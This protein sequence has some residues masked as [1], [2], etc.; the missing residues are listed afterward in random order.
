MHFL[1]TKNRRMRF[2]AFHL[3]EVNQVL[4]A[5][6]VLGGENMDSREMQT[7][8]LP[9]VTIADTYDDIIAERLVASGRLIA[10]SVQEPNGGVLGSVKGLR[11]AWSKV[12]R[13]QS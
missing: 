1:L 3:D 7:C 13:P 10:W 9:A 2:G 12:V 6:S 11:A 8:I 4:F 5:E